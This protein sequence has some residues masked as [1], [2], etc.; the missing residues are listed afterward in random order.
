MIK[1]MATTLII[2]TLIA[3]GCNNSNPIGN[4]FNPDIDY[5][6]STDSR[7]GQSY[8]TVKIGNLVWM[9]ENLN[10]KTDSSWCYRNDNG[11]CLR[12]GRLYIFEDALDACPSGWRLP[13]NSDWD[14]LSQAVGGYEIAGKNLKS[15][16]KWNFGGIGKNELGFSALP[17]GYRSPDGFFYDSGN[18]G[19]WWSSDADSRGMGWDRNYVWKG[20]AND[21]G[22]Y[23]FSVRCLL[24]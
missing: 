16:A 3:I 20:E 7:D 1:L 18:Y 17:G 5:D 12:Y 14:N 4:Q 15:Q 11:E 22:G 19:Y 13:T 2:A 24:D 8:R 23:G 6:S 9:A 10:F 21:Y